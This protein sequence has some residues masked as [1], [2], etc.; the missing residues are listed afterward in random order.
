MTLTTPVTMLINRYLSEAT[1]RIRRRVYLTNIS[2]Q[3]RWWEVL[4]VRNFRTV[5]AFAR[6]Q[7]VLRDFGRYYKKIERLRQRSK[8]I[9][10][11]FQPIQTM[12]REAGEVLGYWYGG[13]LVF[14]G[15]CKLAI[16]SR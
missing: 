10:Q 13:Q 12:L 7:R 6:E 11:L 16:S 15:S 1:Y 5:R 3:T 14:E 8:F 4:D 2:E 9:G